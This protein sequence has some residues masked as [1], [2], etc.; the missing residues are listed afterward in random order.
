MQEAE[1]GSSV[2]AAGIV[3]VIDDLLDG[4]ARSNAEGLEFDLHR[5]HAIDEYNYVVAAVGVVGVEANLLDHLKGVF[6]PVLDIDQ[7]VIERRA[8]IASEALVLAKNRA[9]ANTSG[10]M[11]SSRSR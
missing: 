10:V 8:V 11:I 5:R 2:A 6:A 7:R 9:A 3:L 4:T 1:Q